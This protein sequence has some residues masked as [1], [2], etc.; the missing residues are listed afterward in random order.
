MCSVISVIKVISIR[1]LDIDIDDDNISDLLWSKWTVVVDHRRTAINGSDLEF[2]LRL[3]ML[4]GSP[5]RR[6]NRRS[7]SSTTRS[8]WNGPPA[9]KQL[10]A[11]QRPPRSPSV[12]SFRCPGSTRRAAAAIPAAQRISTPRNQAEGS[13]QRKEPPVFRPAVCTRALHVF[14]EMPGRR[15]RRD[16]TRLTRQVHKEITYKLHNGCSNCLIIYLS[17]FQIFTGV[18]Y[19]VGL[20]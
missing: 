14:E 8:G 9:P 19:T 18:I 7:P 5:P 11:R 4:V 13:R 15:P 2:G 17:I 6:R 12:A 3:Y 1:L 16:S 20:L 10:P